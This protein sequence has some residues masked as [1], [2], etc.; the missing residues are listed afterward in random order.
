MTLAACLA[1]SAVSS[2]K[3]GQGTYHRH[4]SN[5]SVPPYSL[6]ILKKQMVM[7]AKK[8]ASVWWLVHS[9]SWRGGCLPWQAVSLLS[10]EGRYKVAIALSC[11]SM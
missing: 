2:V 3:A 8:G 6:S 9:G 4:P 10:C 11:G 1:C 5:V 7:G